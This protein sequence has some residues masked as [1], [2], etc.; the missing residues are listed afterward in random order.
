MWFKTEILGGVNG[1][2]V[3]IFDASA[4]EGHYGIIAVNL[5]T[6]SGLVKFD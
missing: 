5:T 1:A 4:N 6:P 3:E 2:D